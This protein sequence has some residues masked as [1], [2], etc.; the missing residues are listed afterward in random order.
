MH[1]ATAPGFAELFG[2]PPTVRAR[3]PGRV[4]VIGEHTDYNGGFVLPAAIPQHT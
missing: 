4:N 2:V 3:A 1:S